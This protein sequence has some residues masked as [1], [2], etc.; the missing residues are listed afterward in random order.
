MCMQYSTN[1][2]TVCSSSFD[3]DAAQCISYLPTLVT[4]YGIV[5][6]AR[7]T[8]YWG[9]VG[10]ALPGGCLHNVPQ[11]GAAGA[12]APTRRWT[13]SQLAVHLAHT[14]LAPVPC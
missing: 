5:T 1:P 14:R 11:A 9:K 7:C 8:A 3:F 4:M 13:L 12:L 10:C 6:G 2:K